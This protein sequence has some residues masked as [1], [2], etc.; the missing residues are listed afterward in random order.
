MRCLPKI[1]KHVKQK[2]KKKMIDK[3]K[4]THDH[5]NGDIIRNRTVSIG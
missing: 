5:S 4:N 1:Y 2:I 3:K